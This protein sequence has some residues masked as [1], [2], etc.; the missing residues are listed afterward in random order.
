MTQ[1]GI[2]RKYDESQLRY[3]REVP[4]MTNC[5][6]LNYFDHKITNEQLIET[7]VPRHRNLKIFIYYFINNGEGRLVKQSYEFHH[8]LSKDITFK[9]KEFHLKIRSVC[10]FVYV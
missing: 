3:R 1:A 4:A 7:G 9:L 5:N 8:V 6:V 2:P 10:F